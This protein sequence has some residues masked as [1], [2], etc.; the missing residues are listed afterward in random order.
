M[1]ADVEEIGLLVQPSDASLGKRNKRAS[2]GGEAKG[3]RSARR[4][5]CD[6]TKGGRDDI[7][8]AWASFTRDANCRARSRSPTQAAASRHRRQQQDPLGAG[9]ELDSLAAP[10]STVPV[11]L[12]SMCSC[13]VGPRR[14]NGTG[15]PVQPTRPGRA[16]PGGRTYRAGAAPTA[17]GTLRD[18][19]GGG[20]GI[21]W[22]PDWTG[23]VRCAVG[24][25]GW[26]PGAVSLAR[27]P[28]ASGGRGTRIARESGRVSLRLA[29]IDDVCICLRSPP[30]QPRAP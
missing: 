27:N 21:E 22:A 16:M 12:D 29:V 23:R 10:K 28:A 25:T 14:D 9:R 13:C 7:Q 26:I 5:C 20:G 3:V 19:R 4:D 6:R 18:S 8:I 15:F 11:I 24:W 30:Q 1:V 17:R 2:V